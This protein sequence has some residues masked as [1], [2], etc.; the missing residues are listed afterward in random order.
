MT[1]ELPRPK[2]EG[3]KAR[4]AAGD[5]IEAIKRYREATGAGLAEA[6]RA[7]DRMAEGGPPEGGRLTPENRREMQALILRGRNIDAI[8]LYRA[9]TDCDLEEAKQAVDAMAA[10]LPK[11][12]RAVRRSSGPGAVLLVVLALAAAGALWFLLD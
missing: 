4:I 10:M 2:L 8:R 12:G 11:T 1:E 9:A 7:I 5:W 3:I 6:K